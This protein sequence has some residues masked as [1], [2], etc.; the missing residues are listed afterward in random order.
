MW[1]SEGVWRP[2]GRVRG[3]RTVQRAGESIVV[4]VRG[5]GELARA[6]LRRGAWSRHGRD[7]ALRMMREEVGVGHSGRGLKGERVQSAE[8]P[9]RTC[10]T[11]PTASVARTSKARAVG[12]HG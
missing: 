5:R 9:T 2:R 8:G 12:S 7:D 10:P 6:L 4:A 1:E 3:W 11:E